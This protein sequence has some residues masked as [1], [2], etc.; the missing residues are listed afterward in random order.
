MKI[1]VINLVAK[2]SS[3]FNARKSMYSQILCYVSERFFNIP[4]P[5]KLGKTELQ[6]PDPRKATEILMLSMESRRDSSGTSSQDSIRCSS[7][8]KSKIY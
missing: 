4:N 3:I 8:S 1:S 2:Q 7:A 5:T 6:E